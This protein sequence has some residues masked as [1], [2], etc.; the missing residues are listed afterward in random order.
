MSVAFLDDAVW[1]VCVCL[2]VVGTEFDR[3]TKAT[4]SPLGALLRLL[5]LCV[6]L[7]DLQ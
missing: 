1:R 3:T 2:L 5:I 6:Y 4:A 7:A